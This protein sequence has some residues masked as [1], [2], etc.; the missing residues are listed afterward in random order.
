[1]E[2]SEAFSVLEPIIV[3]CIWGVKPTKLVIYKK[4]GTIL[5]ST[6][7]TLLVVPVIYALISG[8]DKDEQ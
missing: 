1:M 3:V 4:R 8:L 2:E 5:N 7:L 6:L